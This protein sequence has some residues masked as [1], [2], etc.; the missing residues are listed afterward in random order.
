MSSS[1]IIVENWINIADQ[2]YKAKNCFLKNKF[3][4]LLI[5]ECLS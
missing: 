2:N 5:E 4:E 1:M 3:S